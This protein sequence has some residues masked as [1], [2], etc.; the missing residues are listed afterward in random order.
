MSN[1]FLNFPPYIYKLDTYIYIMYYFN[2]ID[3]IEEK[4]KAL[5]VGIK[6][7]SNV[8]KQ[9][10]YLEEF[11]SLVENIDIKVEE[12]ILINLTT[13]NSSTYISKSNVALIKEY[14]ATYDLDIVAFNISLS[15]RALKNLEAELD[16]CVLD[17]E[18]VILQIFASR[19]QTKEAKIQ[20]ELARCEYSLPR[21]TR[22]WASLSQQRGGVKGS[23]GKGEQQLELD[24]RKVERSIVKLKEELK[25]VK[26]TRETQ[27][28]KRIE[29]S[30]YSFGIIGY[31]NAG[32]STLL[33]TLTKANAYAE[34]KLFA[35]LDPQSKKLRL[36][37]GINVDISDTVGFVSNLPHHLI[38][39]FGSTLEIAKDVDCLIILLD[40]SSYNIEAEW[41]TTKEVLESL[42]IKDKPIITVFNKCDL[43]QDE[44]A[45]SRLGRNIEDGIYISLKAK[46]NVDVLLNRMCEVVEENVK[47]EEIIL[48]YD[49]QKE[50]A[51]LYKNKKILSSE[52]R[53]DKIYVKYIK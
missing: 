20:V 40:S 19:A 38:K 32:K 48:N 44:V 45:I 1:S 4:E 53:D 9:S 16:I 51:M 41:E 23:R 12:S 42:E 14:I 13:P 6:D 47:I 33:N 21:L 43:Q 18:E 15:A 46:D 8:L 3:L 29:N 11:Q 37:N 39:A 10:Y 36:A 7:K 52:H 2:M 50:L 34:D 28:K 5:I 31:T 35:T 26:Q 30:L 25:H 17:R 22:R 49:E 24:R 27:K